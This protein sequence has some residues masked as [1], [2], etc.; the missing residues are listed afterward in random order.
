MIQILDIV[1]YAYNIYLMKLLLVG[2]LAA[3]GSSLSM[4]HARSCTNK[5]TDQDPRCN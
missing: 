1:G 3:V 2:I 5:R 4:D